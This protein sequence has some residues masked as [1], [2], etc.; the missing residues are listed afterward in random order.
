MPAKSPVCPVEQRPPPRVGID[1]EDAPLTPPRASSQPAAPRQQPASPDEPREFKGPDGESMFGV[2][3]PRFS[4]DAARNKVYE[5]SFKNAQKAFD[6][7]D[8]W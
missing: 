7:I 2:P 1:P 3:A 8:N 4:L 5:E 6:D